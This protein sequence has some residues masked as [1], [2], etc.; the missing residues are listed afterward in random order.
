MP[1]VRFPENDPPVWTP[2]TGHGGS[3]LS[4]FPQCMIPL[5][6]IMHYTF[7]QPNGLK[8]YY[9]FF[10]FISLIHSLVSLLGFYFCRMA[11]RILCQSFIRDYCFTFLLIW[12]SSSNNLYIHLR[13]RRCKCLLSLNHISINIVRGL[14]C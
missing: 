9:C 1:A 7:H 8:I 2:P 13:C 3:L 12:K 6:M 11:V 4:I 14:F 10:I 5:S